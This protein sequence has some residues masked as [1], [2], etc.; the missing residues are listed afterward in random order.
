MSSF[1]PLRAGGWAFGE[2]LTSAQMN[3]LNTDF[4]FAANMRD[5]AS[6]T[7]SSPVVV[8]GAGMTLKLVGSNTLPSGTLVVSGSASLNIDTGA[9]LLGLAGSATH[10]EFGSQLFVDSGA[11]MH[12]SGI[13]NA[14][15]GSSI[16]LDGPVTMNGS[17]G[18]TIN[19]PAPFICNYHAT[20]NDT[21]TFTSNTSFTNVTTFSGTVGTSGV[22]AFVSVR[23]VER[24]VNAAGA[25]G[26]TASPVTASLYIFLSAVAGSTIQIDDTNAVTGDRIQFVS[27]DVTNLITIKNPGGSTIAQIRTNSG[28]LFA[29]EVTRVSGAPG[30][31][32]WLITGHDLT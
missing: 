29:V 19:S 8:A 30:S 27:K 15:P 18:L 24:I 3:Q 17:G 31:G 32:V 11:E 16:E 4:P 10:W 23:N 9:T 6:Y 22:G 28:D 26:Q 14:D 25:V 13:V 20:F 5:G 2:I 1:L 21:T 7:P 12:I